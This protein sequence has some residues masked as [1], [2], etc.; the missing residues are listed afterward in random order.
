VYGK[1]FCLGVAL[2]IATPA[3]AT[4][5][6]ANLQIRV[7]DGEGAV[8][9]P[10]SRS[11]R[12]LSVEVTDDTGR[13]VE[14]AAVSFH[15]ADDPGSG[16]GGTFANGLRTEVITTDVH[17]RVALH[18]LVLNRVPGRFEIRIIASKEQAR[19]GT[20]SFQYI[21][22]TGKGSAAQA[23]AGGHRALWV[24]LLAAAAGGAT[25]GVLASRS[26]SQPPAVVETPPPLLTIG[27][28]S[29]TLGK[30]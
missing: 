30:P 16:P 12:P 22:G 23:G 6:V 15:V 14:G 25:A 20:V 28:P 18:T 21:A 9:A 5:Q 1:Y 27:A 29:I 11:L 4:A 2:A 19:A 10:G 13:P 26:G 8:H 7:I 3:A 24:V 17:G